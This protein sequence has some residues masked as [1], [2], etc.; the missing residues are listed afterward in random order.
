MSV[1]NIVIANDVGS[2]IKWGSKEPSKLDVNIDTRYLKFNTDGSITLKV[3]SLPVIATK[4]ARTGDVT[5]TNP[6]GTKVVLETPRIRIGVNDN[7]FIDGIDTGRSSKGLKGDQGIQG[8]KGAKGDTGKSAYQEWLDLG[9]TGSEST[10]ISSLGTRIKFATEAEIDTG[11]SI[12]ADKAVSAMEY[13]KEIRIKGGESNPHTLVGTD[14]GKNN[15][16]TWQT[17]IGYRAG[18][19]NTGNGQLA[20]GDNAGKGNLRNGQQ[21]IGNS[22]GTNNSGDDQLAIGNSAGQ[23]NTGNYQVSIGSY[24]GRNNTGISQVAI[25]SSNYG[26]IGLGTNPDSKGA[27]FANVGD[28]QT[29]IGASAGVFNTG[30][31]QTA[32]GSMAG[33]RNTGR[34][35]TAI[36]YDAGYDNTGEAEIAIGAGAGRYNK[37][38]YAIYIGSPYSVGTGHQSGYENCS[39]VTLIGHEARLKSTTESNYVVLGN[40]SVQNIYTSGRYNGTAFNTTSDEKIKYVGDLVATKANGIELRKFTYIANRETTIGWVAQQVKQ[41]LV[42]RGYEEDVINMALPIT[43]DIDWKSTIQAFNE[44]TNS[45]VQ[46]TDEMQPAY[47]AY[48]LAKARNLNV[49]EPTVKDFMDAVEAISEDDRTEWQTSTY[50]TLKKLLESGVQQ[51]Y[52]WDDILTINKQLVED[53]LG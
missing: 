13:H 27:G 10:F 46:Y 41:L 38:N 20:I 14:A 19:D 16:G 49:K 40:N 9:N 32:I 15:T 44:A 34:H 18:E 24:A 8:L 43:R 21:A 53:L 4:D 17:A 23:S 3:D 5:I 12:N 45:S 11:G 30:I 51:Y 7:W 42:S 50:N 47:D 39:H 29:A 25:G 33:S 22:A 28:N 52:V 31:S 6:N 48:V 36:G 2:S 37:I 1:K 35:Q 26:N